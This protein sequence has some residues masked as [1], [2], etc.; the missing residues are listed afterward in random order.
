M[1]DTQPVTWRERVLAAINWR[2]YLSD[3]LAIL[4]LSAIAA[5]L[6]LEWPGGKPLAFTQAL[7]FIA[8][9][10]TAYDLVTS[11]WDGFLGVKGRR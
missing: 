9:I 11:F 8:V 10:T 5:W 4:L 6:P 3:L 1:Y 2:E 7:G